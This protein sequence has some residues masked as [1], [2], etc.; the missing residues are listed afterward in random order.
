MDDVNSTHSSTPNN[1][2]SFGSSTSLTPSDG[3]HD[4]RF[5]SSPASESFSDQPAGSGIPAGQLDVLKAGFAAIRAEFHVAGPMPPEVEEAAKTAQPVTIGRRDATD[6]PMVTLDPASSTDLDQAFA[7]SLEPGPD[8]GK[9]LI[10]A[11][12]VLHYAIADI[13]AF[14]PLGGVIETEAWKRGTTVYAPDGSVPVYPRSLSQDRAS[15]L[16]EGPRPCIL[17]EVVVAPDGTPVLRNIERATIRSRAKLAYETTT[18][19]DLAPEAVELARRVTEAE[20]RRGAFRVE[21]DEQEVVLDAAL[22]LG[23]A[24]RFAAR[25]ESEDLN[26]CVSLSANMAVAN[27][28][29]E[30]GVGLFRIMND[31]DAAELASLRRTAR[32]LDV[33]WTRNE[34]LRQ[35]VPRLD[36]K[37]P[38]HIAFSISARRSGGG[39]SYA[40]FPVQAVPAI[41]SLS[42]A[43]DVGGLSGVGGVSTSVPPAPNPPIGL[44]PLATADFSVR[45]Q[46]DDQLRANENPS[47]GNANGNGIVRSNGAA[48]QS[49]GRSLGISNGNGNGNGNVNGNGN[50]RDRPAMVLHEGKPWHSAMAAPY[51]HATAPM[52]RLADRYV[53]EFLL[54]EFSG[55]DAAKTALLPKLAALPAVMADA[56]HRAAKVDRACLDY[57]ECVI[58][59]SRVG[60]T[61]E[62]T[63]LEVSREIAQFT[64]EDPCVVA[65]IRV[66]KPK[67]GQ[68]EVSPGDELTVRLDAVD[69][70]SRRLSF[71]VANT[72]G[73]QDHN[74]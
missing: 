5:A 19:A 72:N 12:I 48:G 27:A 53:L 29:I 42:G 41:P 68:P 56:D 15:L 66:P 51:A 7:F 23:V 55:D 50:D 25:A 44:S 8:G 64:I 31:P 26:A 16:P 10:R 18:K 54:A 47:D 43:G 11:N 36:V 1:A 37:N 57:V 63:V 61:F 39:A 40:V 73:T 59:A 49:N 17:L 58:L 9:D 71:S 38:K 62:A 60:E 52:R 6:L 45:T 65:R 34:S 69:P 67:P 13:G 2:T 14:A 74:V 20:D 22:P 24:V 33:N 30:R 21:L 35:V 3:V 28:M 4:L 32:T 46:T 70:K